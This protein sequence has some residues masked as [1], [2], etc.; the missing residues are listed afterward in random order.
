MKTKDFA[1]SVKDVSDD[2][3][4]EGYASVFG[5][6]DSYGEICMPG[7]FGSSLAKHRREGTKPLL[8]WQHDA[9]KPLGVW[10]DLAEDGKGLW[11]KARLLPG[12]KQADEA[13]ILLRAGALRGL[14]IGYR[15]IKA[16]PDGAHRR[17]LDLDLI[18]ASIVSFPAN[19]RARI[20]AVKTD[21]TDLGERWQSWA[22]SVRDGEPPAAK[23]F[24]Q[25]LRDAGVPKSVAVAIASVGYTKAFRG[26]PEGGVKAQHDAAADVLAALRDAVT[27]FSR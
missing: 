6:V 9:A 27:A 1:L 4:F 19:R 15:E 18:E 17:L 3:T 23:D 2:G 25:L 16:E 12:V 21:I 10:E 26:E 8:L 5:N 24:E 7:C 13:L 11:G 22:R 14:S 20:E